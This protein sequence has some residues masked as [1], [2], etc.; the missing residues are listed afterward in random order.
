MAFAFRAEVKRLPERTA[1]R[2]AKEVVEKF[3]GFCNT[4]FGREL[5]DKGPNW[6]VK[7]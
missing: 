2:M 4:E 6:S 3:V 5:M 1:K 7:C